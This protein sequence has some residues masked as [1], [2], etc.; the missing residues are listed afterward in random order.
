MSNARLYHDIDPVNFKINPLS[1]VDMNSAMADSK[2]FWNLSSIFY[3]KL[4]TSVLFSRGGSVSN[5]TSATFARNF[6]KGRQK[7]KLLLQN[8]KDPKMEEAARKRT[9]TVPLDEVNFNWQKENC[10]NHLQVVGQ[11]YNI[12]SDVYSMKPFRPISVM[13]VAYAANSVMCGNILRPSQV[14]DE[15]SVV[16]PCTDNQTLRGGIKP[17]YWTLVLSNIDGHVYTNQ[18][19]VLHW[20]V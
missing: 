18:M 13:D 9:L 11:H 12:F 17:V 8:R 7:A 1:V 10:P 16:F 6:S 15:P 19:E 3:S 4:F 5:Y 14:L 20:M 2:L